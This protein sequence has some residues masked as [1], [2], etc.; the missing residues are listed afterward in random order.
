MNAKKLVPVVTVC[1]VLMSCSNQPERHKFPVSGR[2]GGPVSPIVHAEMNQTPGLKSA[3]DLT[4]ASV[5]EEVNRYRESIGTA[6]LQRHA[7]LDKLAKQHSE[8][9]RQNRGTFSLYGSNVSHMGSSG[10]STVAMKIYNMSSTSENVASMSRLS[11]TSADARGLLNLWK[12]SPKHHEALKNDAWTHTGI[13]TVV[14][15]DG[16]IF[17]T[18]LFGS[19]G[20]TQMISRER[21]R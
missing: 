17:S 11:S 19:M 16:T 12:N 5:H 9:L 4:S 2:V 3:G 15:D 14:D 21:F 10:R 8:Y 6:P 7:G 13:G 18:Q 20:M 1:A